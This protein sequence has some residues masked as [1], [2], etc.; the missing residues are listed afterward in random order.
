MQET[1]FDCSAEEWE[2]ARYHAEFG[3]RQWG[4]ETTRRL[5]L[6][7]CLTSIALVFGLFTLGA[8][9]TK[10]LPA[11]FDTVIGVA[12]YACMAL[13]IVYFI[14]LA[15]RM[16]KQEEQLF[17]TPHPRQ[18]IDYLIVAP[19]GFWVNTHNN[20]TPSAMAFIRW[21]KLYGIYFNNTRDRRLSD[22]NMLVKQQNFRKIQAYLPDFR[23][24]AEWEYDNRFSLFM[25]CRDTFAYTVQL[26][27]PESWRRDGQFI[28]LVKLI[29]TYARMPVKPARPELF[30][31]FRQWLE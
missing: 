11:P 30:P 12:T 6:K 3:G 22:A 21:D 7:G 18:N 28:R 1:R 8:A 20:V 4:S 15:A 29:E 10:W 13:V 2:F 16:S 19:E 24:D 26:Q 31:I 5:S 9:G 23:E 14:R 17:T 25:D 27:L